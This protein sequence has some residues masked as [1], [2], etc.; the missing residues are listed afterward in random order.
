[1]SQEINQDG[2]GQSVSAGDEK[3]VDRRISAK[4]EQSV[5]RGISVTGAETS[6]E[7]VSVA[8]EKARP[9][10]KSSAAAEEAGSGKRAYVRT[11]EQMMEDP[12]DKCLIDVRSR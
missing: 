7:K 6:V 4:D 1:M 5:D 8:G 2:M 11:I 3:S 12:R 10:R 9:G